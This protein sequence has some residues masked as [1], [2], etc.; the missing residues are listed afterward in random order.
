MRLMN[1]LTWARMNTE[2]Y[3]SPHANILTFPFL[4]D[5]ICFLLYTSYKYTPLSLLS[6]CFFFLFFLI[7]I[8]ILSIL[9]LHKVTLQ[10]HLLHLLS[11]STWNI[12]T[13]PVITACTSQKR[14]SRGGLLWQ[15]VDVRSVNIN[16]TVISERAPSLLI[17]ELLICLWRAVK[18]LIEHRTTLLRRAIRTLPEL[19]KVQQKWLSNNEFLFI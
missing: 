10:H 5:L 8:C 16:H 9:P 7:R 6:V 2:S 12:Q 11:F 3:T 13:I 1:K 18:L 17:M 15:T 4:S 19:L 14:V